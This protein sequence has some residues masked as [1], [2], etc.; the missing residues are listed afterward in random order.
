MPERESIIRECFELAEL[1]KKRG[2][3]PFGSIII[4]EGG[5]A[6]ARAGNTTGTDGTVVHH[7]EINAI[8]AT[9]AVKGKGKLEAC[10]L[11]TS[12]EPCPMCAAAIVWSGISTVIYGVSI[13]A[14]KEVGI[15]QIEIDSRSIF[16]KSDHEIKVIGPLLENEGLQVFS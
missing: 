12:A 2:D 7:A 14:M 4:D 15:K 9:E 16:S 10:T 11:F 13:Q 3:G 6:I 8:R 1:A 5:K